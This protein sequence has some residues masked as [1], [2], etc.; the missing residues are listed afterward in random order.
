VHY[1]SS[2]RGHDS[3]PKPITGRAPR[4]WSP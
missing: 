3:I 1:G 4:H 2:E